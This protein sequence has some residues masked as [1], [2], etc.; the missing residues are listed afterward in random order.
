MVGTAGRSG[1]DRFT[2]SVDPTKLDGGPVKPEL[3]EALSRIW[4]ALL[5]QLHQPSLRNVDVHEIKILVELLHLKAQLW[6]IVSVD[7]TDSKLNRQY[8]NVVDRI[9]KL[10]AVFGL[11]P[12][13]RRRL[14]QDVVEVQDAADEWLQS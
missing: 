10:S 13:D 4:D 5:P 12:S 3:P 8:I 14:K 2:D 7:P 9:H 6:E 11:N 1:G